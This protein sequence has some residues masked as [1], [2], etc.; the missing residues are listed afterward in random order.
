MLFSP[1]EKE[2]I[3]RLLL[4]EEPNSKLLALQLLEAAPD[5]ILPLKRALSTAA[6]LSPQFDNEVEGKIEL[7]LQKHLAAA[8]LYELQNEIMILEYAR[9]KFKVRG[10]W[11]T[12]NNPLRKYLVLHEMHLKEYLPIFAHN[13]NRFAQYYSILA[14]RIKEE[15]KSNT[16]AL[17]FH[18]V[19][20]SLVPQH[21][22]S[23]YAYARLFHI[24]YLQKGK[25]LIDYPK[26]KALYLTSFHKKDRMEP[27][28]NAAILCAEMK[29]FNHSR[30]L[31]EEALSIN[32]ED[33]TVLNNYANLL[34]KEFGDFKQA[35]EIASKALSIQIEAATLDTMA[36]IEMLGFNNLA[37]AKSYFEQALQID[38]TSHW[39]HTGLGDWYILQKNYE[40]A[41]KEYHLGLFKNMQ[42]TTRDK[43]DVIEKLEKFIALYTQH[44]PNP[45]K[46]DYY[47][48]K[49]RK[50]EG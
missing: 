18:E 46:A 44:L 3:T 35:K 4:S 26:I 27:Y 36:H 38:S 23:Q 33:T 34:F 15:M 11:H 19:V 28:I 1:K 43:K 21:K 42:F 31:Y 9:Y 47:R 20:L 48:K 30:D 16:K 7:V 13:A 37:K 6:Y 12:P 14:R 29:D 10:T 24:H 32:P 25:R 8:Q 17:F 39:A 45:I 22:G 2:N 5:N 50:L 41:A 49:L 40:L